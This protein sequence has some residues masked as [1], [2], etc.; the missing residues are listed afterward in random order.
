MHV[1]LLF[2]LVFGIISISACTKQ[3]AFVLSDLAYPNVEGSVGPHL[4]AGP[5]GT[6]VLSWLEPSPEGH[7]LKFAN[8]SGDAWSTPSSVRN[9]PNLMA[10]WADFPSVVS[11]SKNLWVAHWLV[12][13][14]GNSYGY[15]AVAAFPGMAESIGRHLFCCTRT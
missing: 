12:L 9:G 15:D 5:T 7:A 6:G 4:V 11:V 1:R 10:N 2:L 13:Q 3:P 8:Y 14:G